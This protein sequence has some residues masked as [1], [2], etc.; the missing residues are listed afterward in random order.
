[1]AETPYT[2][3]SFEQALAELETTVKRLEEERLPLDEA[4]S[5]Y[6]KGIALKKHCEQKLSEARMRVEQITGEGI[7]A[8][9]ATESPEKYPERS[10]EIAS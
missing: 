10:S 7:I 9:P 6:E 3:W 4:I 8:F 5:A 1:M 2:S